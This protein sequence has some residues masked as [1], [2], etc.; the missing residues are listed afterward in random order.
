MYTLIVK[1]K[2]VINQRLT[3]FQE[4][5]RKRHTSSRTTPIP[6][7]P[8]GTRRHKAVAAADYSLRRTKNRKALSAA[9]SSV[10][11]PPRR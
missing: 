10:A 4:E 3:P 2:L 7:S 5:K 6:S 1:Y 9:G 8:Q 11:K